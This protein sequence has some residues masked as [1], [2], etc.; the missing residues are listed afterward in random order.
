MLRHTRGA[1]F[2]FLCAIALAVIVLPLIDIVVTLVQVAAPLLRPSLFAT[3]TQAGG[4]GVEN[5]I[6]GSLLVGA[7]V[8]VVAGPIGILAGMYIAEFASGRP[9]A[10]LR[11]SSEVLSGVPS[12]VV[13]YVG[14]VVLV[15]ALGWGY[16]LLAAVTALSMLIL[17][18]VVK[19]T[20]V[21][22]ESVPRSLREGAAALGLS[23]LTTIRKVL[24]P[25]AFPLIVSGLVL[26]EAIAT[27]ET[28]PLLFTANW[29]DLNPQPGLTHNPF[30]YLT[31]TVYYSFNLPS[32]GEHQLAFAAAL[33]TVAMILLMIVAGRLITLRARRTTADLEV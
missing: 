33:V 27:G 15:K 3:T 26:A 2:W 21:A 31:G 12:I 10:V 5:G 29:S 14:Y 1:I 22:F 8:L 20:E 13:G 25:P 7:G 18:Y 11:F 24:L 28:A 16:S 23:R 19:N 30:G 6:L 32:T 4:L 9:R 17:P